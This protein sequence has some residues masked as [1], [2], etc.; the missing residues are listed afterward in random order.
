M[1]KGDLGELIARAVAT[2]LIPLDVHVREVVHKDHRDENLE[3]ANGPDGM[4]YNIV[5][6]VLMSGVCVSLLAHHGVTA[7]QKP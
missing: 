6:G 3:G 1:A 7:L 4:G 5:G 2:A